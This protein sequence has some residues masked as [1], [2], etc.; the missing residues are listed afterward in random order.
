MVGYITRMG[1]ESVAKSAL[2]WKNVC[3]IWVEVGG[4]WEE[5]GR[6]RKDDIL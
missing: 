1:M 3:G 6:H 5:K 2:S 4:G